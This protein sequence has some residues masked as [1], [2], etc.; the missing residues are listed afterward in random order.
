MAIT[1]PHNYLTINKITQL[2]ADKREHAVIFIMLTINQLSD[3]DQI[4]AIRA[5]TASGIVA[6][7]VQKR[8]AL[9]SSS[10]FCQNEKRKSPESLSRVALSTTGNCWFEGLSTRKP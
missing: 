7:L 4:A 6:Q 1:A 9:W 2:R 5:S 10:T 8:T 3:T